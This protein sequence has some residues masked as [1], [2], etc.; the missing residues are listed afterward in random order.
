MILPLKKWHV[1][2]IKMKAITS[3]F[4]A[5]LQGFPL[6]ILSLKCSNCTKK[7]AKIAGTRKQPF[8]NQTLDKGN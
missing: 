3:V 6:R 1:L 5:V 8:T 4:Q 7:A 2:I